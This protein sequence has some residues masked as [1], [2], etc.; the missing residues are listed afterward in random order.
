MF[1]SEE[2]L[3]NIRDHTDIVKLISGYVNLKRSG[4]SYMGLCPFHDE[5]SASFSVNPAGQY[6]HCF[7]CG[8]GGS[9][10]KFLMEYENCTFSEAVERLA[11]AAGI[12]LEKR[13][14]TE[15]E[16]R[17]KSARERMYEINSAAA[18]Y[19]YAAL[20]DPRGA[21]GFKYFEGRGLSQDTIRNFALG[22]SFPEGGLIPYLKSQGFS[23]REMVDAGLARMDEKRGLSEYFWNRVIF[24]IVNPNK[25][26]I[27]FGGR[28]MGDA[29]PKYLNSKENLI[30]EKGRNLYGLNL[31]KKSRSDFMILCEGYMDVISMHQA[32]FSMAVASLGT[33]MTPAQASLLKRYTKKLLL[34]YDSDE[35]G[36]KAAMRAIQIC[37]SSGLVTKVVR[38]APYKDPDE[39]IKAEGAESFSKRLAEAVNSFYFE[40]EILERD[41][42]MSDPGSR[43]EFVHEAARRLCVFEDELE[44]D[45]YVTAVASK[46]SIEP[47]KLKSEVRKAFLVKENIPERPTLKTKEDMRQSET[48]E[49]KTERLLLTALA[50][51]P[52]LFD[53]IKKYVLPEDFEDDTNRKVAELLYKQLFEGIF[54]PAAIMDAFSQE[55][56]NDRISQIFNSR[57]DG[58]DSGRE[59]D[60]YVSDLVRKVRAASLRRKIPDGS[61]DPLESLRQSQKQSDELKKIYISLGN[62]SQI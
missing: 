58:V 15:E 8:K 57:Y 28:V 27:G 55:D 40:L 3:N 2:V 4:S 10:F 18:K 44:R 45:N 51:H 24:P 23:D 33:A 60:E 59:Y 46:Y 36:I 11:E 62:I 53:Q 31:A 16:K 38:L 32:G 5:R 42:D 47:E 39:F 7:G 52:E 20:K 35:P 43:T 49:T 50:D 21:V 61:E 54:A 37:R 41:F 48:G 1:Y 26:V 30:F 29:K 17:Q 22:F 19:Y 12:T 56:E 13:E 9:A 14:A 34:I 6:Y 25:K